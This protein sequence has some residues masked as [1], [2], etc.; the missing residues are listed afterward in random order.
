M[1]ASTPSLPFVTPPVGIAAAPA[2]VGGTATGGG[3]Q[4][5]L[6]VVLHGPAD[7][8]RA[9]PQAAARARAEHRLL[10]VV[11]VGPARTWTVGA[12]VIAVQERRRH[13]EVDSMVNAARRICRQLEVDVRDVIVL[14]PSWTW[15]RRHRER[16]I[17]RLLAALPLHRGAELHPPGNTAEPGTGAAL[18][19]AGAR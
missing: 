10:T 9:L 11:V 1:S 3:G 12:T 19:G 16:A 17:D 13:R 14:Q 8:T 7:L 2:P 6:L 4:R 5:D 15:T 18:S